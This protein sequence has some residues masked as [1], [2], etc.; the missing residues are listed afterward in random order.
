[1]KKNFLL[2]IS[3]L[4]ILAGNAQNSGA[5]NFKNLWATANDPL[6]RFDQLNKQYEN[7]L[8]TGNGNVDSAASLEMLDIAQD[9]DNDSLL[10]ISYNI[11]GNYFCFNKGEYSIGLEYLFKAIPLAGKFNDARRVSSL[12]FDIG[13]IYAQLNNPNEAITYNRKGAANLPSKN[14]AMYDFMI[15]QYQDNMSSS[16]LQ[17][18]QPDSALHYAQALNETN[19]GSRSRHY[20]AIALRNF[21]AVYEQLGDKALAQIYYNKAVALADS[22]LSYN[23]K[24]ATK[25]SYANFLLNNNNTGEAKVQARELLQM[26][27]Q[28]N[29]NE[30]KEAGA[31]LLRRV[32]DQLNQI[33]SAYFYSRM[34]ST[35][36]ASIFSQ[37]NLNKIEA[38]NFNEKLRSMEEADRIAD[39]AERRWLNMQYV[40]I[41][42]GIICFI[43]LFLL[44]SRSFITNHKIIEFLGVIA[45]LIVFE[46]LNM[47]LHPVVEKATDHSPLLMLLALVCIAAMLVPLHHRLEKWATARLVE[48]NKMIRLA[49]ARKTIEQLEKPGH[50]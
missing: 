18:K 10:A 42:F 44:L 34:E 28:T 5:D 14:S 9:L 13:A 20:D 43:M 37:D 38:L 6:A 19:L 25:R 47:L 12:F 48:K 16:F 29:N 21:A 39:L 30:M 27:G 36:H 8:L 22:L 23:N 4:I 15:R 49:E 31:G 2:A 40:L 7:L 1:M 3:F 32:Y 50:N 17:L 35:I 26:G 41:A 33:D 46:F 45:L 11:L 24:L